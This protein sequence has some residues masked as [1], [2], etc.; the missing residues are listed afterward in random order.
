LGAG[1]ELGKGLTGLSN[2]EIS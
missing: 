1:S 2:R